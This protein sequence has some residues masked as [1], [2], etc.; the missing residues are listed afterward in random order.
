MR[1]RWPSAFHVMTTKHLTLGVVWEPNSGAHYRA[2]EP[3]KAMARRGHEIVWPADSNGEAHLRR[4]AGCHAVHVYR[5]GNDE[6]RRVLAELARAGVA[7]TYDNDDDFTA[8]P[9]ESRLYKTTGGLAGQRIF[10][11]TAKVARMARCFSTTSDALADKYRRAGVER[12][13][14]IGNYLSPDAFRAPHRH[15]GIVIGWIASQEHEADVAR[16]EIREALGRLVAA[17]DDVR[18][19]CIGVDLKLPERYGHDRFVPFL[20][21]PRRI[22]GFDIGIA[23]LADIP[24]NRTRSDIK[25]KEYAASGVP[26]L[27][28]P[29]GP[30]SGL[31][32]DQG[33]RLV[34]DDGWFEALDRLVSRR[35]ERR[36]LARKARAWAKSQTIDAVADRWE[37][38]FMEAV[39]EEERV[40]ISA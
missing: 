10:A 38:L 37:Q 2:I 7:I 8:V 15:H 11:E 35:R 6:T 31:G 28:S 17:H 1:F 4:L 14:V 33:G 24:Y 21:L 3:M 40:E 12:V 29:V 19:E 30:Y 26:W 25:L 23:P 13:E 27:A 22:G 36:R 16:I 9:K 39:R 18:V 20:E 32:E 34:P 5:R